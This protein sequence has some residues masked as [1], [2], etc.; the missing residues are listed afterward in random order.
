MPPGLVRSTQLAQAAAEYAPRAIK[1]ACPMENWPVKPLT[2][3]SDTASVTPIPA[4]IA[5][6]AK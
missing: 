4:P 1:P 6:L 5:T 3:F 2:M